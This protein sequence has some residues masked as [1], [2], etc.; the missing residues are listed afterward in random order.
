MIIQRE[1]LFFRWDE[2]GWDGLPWEGIF[3]EEKEDGNELV[4]LLS[5]ARRL[6]VGKESTLSKH[7]FRARHDAVLIPF[8]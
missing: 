8:H 7:P 3:R 6:S 5:L 4:I 2:M 1:H